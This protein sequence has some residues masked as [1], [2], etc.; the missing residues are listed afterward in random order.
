MQAYSYQRLRQ[1]APHISTV[2]SCPLA[3]ACAQNSQYAWC[4][5]WVRRA[6]WKLHPPARMAASAAMLARVRSLFASA[7]RQNL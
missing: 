3:H 4:H 2:P 5:E 7:S 6:R 1:A